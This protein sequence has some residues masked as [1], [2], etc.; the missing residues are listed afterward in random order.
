LRGSDE[1]KAWVEDFAHSDRATVTEVID[2]ALEHYAE[3][4]GFKR[5][6]KR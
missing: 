2:R 4:R 5:P 3:K 1:W 6:P